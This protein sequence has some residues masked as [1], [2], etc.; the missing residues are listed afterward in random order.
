MIEQLGGPIVGEGF[1]WELM[2]PSTPVVSKFTA[3]EWHKIHTETTTDQEFSAWLLKYE[4]ICTPLLLLRRGVPIGFVF[5]V[6]DNY[7]RSSVMIHGGTWVAGHHYSPTL[8]RAMVALSMHLLDKGFLV[9]SQ[10]NI[11]NTVSERF[12]RGCGFVPYAREDGYIKFYITQTTIGKSRLYRHQIEHSRPPQ[13][14]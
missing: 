6:Y 3:A 12:L 2:S 1:K 13:P 7:K 8:F 11:R 5:V 9:H 14:R 10:C 4:S